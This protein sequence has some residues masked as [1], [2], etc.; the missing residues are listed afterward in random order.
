MGRKWQKRAVPGRN[1][2]EPW[3]VLMARQAAEEEEEVG[4][5]G[6]V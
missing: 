3:Q 4:R 1:K 2:V 6:C 5:T